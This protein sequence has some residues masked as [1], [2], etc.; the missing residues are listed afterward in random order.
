M[1]IG[2]IGLELI[3]VW[4]L[5]KYF[6]NH[7]ILFFMRLLDSRSAAIWM[8]SITTLPG[9]LVHEIAHFL[10]AAFMGLRTGTIELLPVLS[11]SGGVEFGSVQVEKADP[12]RLALV[13]LAP[14][15]AG[16]P[17]VAWMSL[18]MDKS[19]LLWGY[20]IVCVTT[21]L[22]PSKKDMTYWPVTIA[23]IGLLAWLG[24]YQ[25]SNTYLL[26]S[27]AKGLLIPI[28]VLAGGTLLFMGINTLMGKR[29]IV[30]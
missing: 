30:Q 22:L 10:S 1:I 6:A 28:L 16:L 14:L 2:L 23:V 25:F 5:R 24:I 13:G 15:I 17:L 9:L 7:F 3:V 19:Y 11:D 26:E 8:Y 20:L 18:Q 21:H 4:F 12:I 29:N 27:V